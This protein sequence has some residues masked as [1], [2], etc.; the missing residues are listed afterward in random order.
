MARGLGEAKIKKGQ[1]SSAAEQ[2]DTTKD[3]KP[4]KVNK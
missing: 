4:L 1:P 2:V 3:A